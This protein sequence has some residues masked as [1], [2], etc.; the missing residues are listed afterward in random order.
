MKRPRSKIEEK[1]LK[2]E[3]L[4]KAE[5]LLLYKE[6]PLEVVRRLADARRRALHGD[7]VFYNQNIHLEPTNKCVYSC[8]FCAF[9]RKPKATEAEGAWDYSLED[10]EAILDR[11][12]GMTLTEIHIT[13]GVHPTHD[14]EWWCEL[15]R[16]VK[17]WRPSIHVKAYTAVEIAWMANQSKLSFRET[18]LR[19]KQAG[20][21]SLPA[22]GAEIFAPEIRKKIAGGKA[23]ANCW[24]EIH[25]TAHR[26]GIQS[27][28]SMLYGHVETL[29]QRLDHMIALRDLQ[30]K[31]GGFNAFIP[32]KYRHENNHLSHLPELSEAQDLR[33]Y[34]VARLMIHNIKH[35]K[36]YWAMLG[37]ETARKSLRYGADDLDGTIYDTT[38]IYSMAGS[39]SKPSL[40]P[41]ELR[42]MIEKNGF[43]PVERDSLYQVLHAA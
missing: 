36:T 23:P 4:S 19:L 6:F 13:G 7:Q 9:Y 31:T 37:L 15:I 16:R 20:L 17:K 1:I 28:A 39:I 18:L 24:L 14:L 40:T 11:Y 38:K 26:L 34:A 8:K 41:Q 35:I 29:E 2:L 10:V 42:V 21:D 22:G 5:G 25:E 32:L 27:N 3:P 12:E 43:V 33:N 30:E